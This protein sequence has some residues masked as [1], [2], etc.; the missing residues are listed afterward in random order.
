[1][2]LFNLE[3]DISIA[4]LIYGWVVFFIV[5]THYVW[6]LIRSGYRNNLIKEWY[7]PFRRSFLPA[8][9]LT[10]ILFLMS[11]YQVLDGYYLL[12]P[13]WLSG[14]FY[15]IVFVASAHFMLNLFLLNGWLFDDNLQLNHHKPTWFIL[16]SANFIIV[17]ALMGSFGTQQNTW[18][19]EVSHFFFAVALFLWIVFSTSLFYRLI[20]SQALQ[21]PLRPSLFIF[22]AP[23]SLGCVASLFISDAYI[24]NGIITLDS[25]GILSWLSY[26]FASVMLLIWLVNYRFFVGG[27]LSMAGWSYVYP[28]AAYGLASQYLA[29]ALEN[30]YLAIF[31]AVVFVGLLSLILLLSYWLFKEVLVF[32]R[33]DTNY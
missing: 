4:I 12:D 1:M 8:V 19:Y 26:G 24:A 22:L 16:L 25:V 32:I 30:I 7:D 6:H 17:I 9:S 31:S 5:S 2:E 11:L 18:I 14:L 21:A 33:S 20:F 10:T 23:P 28:L 3:M 15:A 29:Q 13:A 27:G